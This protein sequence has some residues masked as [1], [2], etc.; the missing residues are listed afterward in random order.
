MSDIEARL[1]DELE[2]ILGRAVEQ[3]DLDALKDMDMKT[4]RIINSGGSQKFD[5][6]VKSIAAN[7]IQKNFRG[8]SD[9]QSVKL[10]KF[11]LNRL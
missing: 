7:L 1:D 3:K 2:K 6:Y 4:L 10:M 9:R 5:G 8:H 11:Q